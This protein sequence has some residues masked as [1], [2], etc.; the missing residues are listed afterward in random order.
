MGKKLSEDMERIDAI[1]RRNEVLLRMAITH[2]FDVGWKNIT[3]GSV[4]AT[5][6]YIR[7]EEKKYKAM[8]KIPVMSGDFQVALMETCLELKQFSPVT[9][10]VYVSNYL[11]FCE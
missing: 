11:R 5:I 2:L 6:E 8:G 1:R 4:E 7:K 9:L 3:P 10:L